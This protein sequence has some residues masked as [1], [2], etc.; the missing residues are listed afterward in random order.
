MIGALLIDGANIVRKLDDTFDGNRIDY[1]KLEEVLAREAGRI[2]GA[3]ATFSFKNYYRTVRP[4]GKTQNFFAFQDYLK[5]RGWYMDVREAKKYPAGVWH[6]K[7][8]DIAMALDAHGLALRKYV[9]FVVLVTHDADFAALFE[10]LPTHIKGIIVGWEKHMA[11]ELKWAAT[12]IY[13]DAFWKEI[14]VRQSVPAT[15]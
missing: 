13:L 4:D 5:K 14:Q 8:T 6:D 3:P 1:G 2:V 9:D 12:P 15:I 11:Q 10:R 7:G